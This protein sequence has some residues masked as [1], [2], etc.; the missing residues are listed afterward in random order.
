MVV[1]TGDPGVGKTALFENVIAHARWRG[2]DVLRA[3]GVQAESDIPLAAL[4]QLTHGLHDRV[5]ELPP[6]QRD[7][8][9]VAF[10]E[11]EGSPADAFFLGI[12]TLT[13]LSER[14]TSAGLLI[15]VDDLQWVDDV[16]SKV[17]AFVARRVADEPILLLV[18][19]R[20]GLAR[21]EWE[22]AEFTRL[23]LGALDPADASL[24]LDSVASTL[25]SSTR[26]LVL[27]RSQGNPLALIE[28]SESPHVWSA[29]S[30][31]IVPLTTRLEQAFSHRLEP[32]DNISRTVLLVAAVS[33]DD[34]QAA[35]LEAA[36]RIV[37][38]LIL[39]AELD[40]L[41]DS[42]L[43]GRSRGRLIFQHP[44]VRSAVVQSATRQQR[45]R[46]HRS[47]AALLPPGSDRAI[48]H[49]AV[50]TEGADD[51][52]A[53]ALSMG[54]DRF[55]SFGAVDA[56]VSA[57][58][59]ASE[60]SSLSADRAHRLLLA[61]E[62]AFFGFKTEQSISLLAEAELAS[63]DV[64]VLARISWIR[65]LLP[66]GTVGAGDWE[67]ALTVIRELREAG[68]TEAAISALSTLAF[69][70]A[71]SIPS[72]PYW[73]QIVDTV[74]EYGA[75][76]NDARRLQ[77][78]AL[79]AP[80]ELAQSVTA[81]LTAMSTSPVSNPDGLALLAFAAMA[82]GSITE[83]DR[84]GSAAVDEMKKTGR[85]AGLGHQ[86]VLMATNQFFQG[87]TSEARLSCEESLA[88]AREIREPFLG[89]TARLTHLWVLAPEGHA[90][91]AE[92]LM[93]E[94]PEAAM[95]LQGG[96]LRMHYLLARGTSEA[97]NGRYQDAFATL[98]ELVDPSGAS[99]HW[100]YGS[101]GL[102]EYADAAA[103]SG[104]SEK[105]RAVV[106]HY[107][108][109]TSFAESERMT[110]ELWFAHAV[111]ALDDREDV[112]ARACDPATN[113]LPYLRARAN[114]RYGEWLRR[115]KNIGEAR[116]R[117]RKARDAFEELGFRRWSD[118]ARAELTATGE[119]SPR[120][121]RD[122]GQ[123][124][125]PQEERVVALAATGMT[126]REIAQALFLSPRTVGA[127]LYSAYPKLGIAGRGEL[128]TDEG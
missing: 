12:A 71:T 98:S 64:T 17:L 41:V 83:T 42:G 127:H 95:A 82:S 59:R 27:Q 62:T 104:N 65:Q 97:A 39:P 121:K 80:S 70:G 38:R 86:L 30:G 51:D 112:F 120:L 52:L 8:L 110:G 100:A 22:S 7:A 32:L 43:V 5:A 115:R 58:V 2:I 46:A 101:R 47:V 55:R 4:H 109:I 103:R 53:Q 34:A 50:V 15:V 111:L 57:Y 76:P 45:E 73:R 107:G 29:A 96:V 24:L 35:I 33:S 126:N 75:E 91:D 93:R 23:T 108:A 16:T 31:D 28:L 61:A 67:K 69:H 21:P 94:Y 89:L 1:V 117:L 87:R 68:N 3:T 124:L 74:A 78:E 102:S 54:G 66:G 106:G 125:T 14:A 85:L 36:G 48:W 6:P 25:S 105:A 72:G 81:R 10:G 40:V 60:L 13:L 77:I 79:G 90:V 119:R 92:E 116:L 56:A 26:E 9:R 44:L 113:P 128:K 49:L 123:G 20:S 88:Y 19:G 18:G 114:L 118:I 84:F 37:G 11:M 122:P 63:T 99:Y